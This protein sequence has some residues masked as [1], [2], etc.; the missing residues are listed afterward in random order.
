M[1]KQQGSL[2]I[3]SGPSGVGKTTLVTHFLQQY[4]HLYNIDRVV[5]YTTKQPRSTEVCGVDYHFITQSEFQDKIKSGFFLEWSGEYGAFY[6][7]PLHIIDALACGASK[8]LVIDRVGA[9]QI[10]KR[11]PETILCW[12]Q[13]SS[14]LELMNRLANRK[15]ESSEQVQVRLLLAKKEIEQEKYQPMYHHYIENNELKS[16]VQKLF[17]V[18]ASECQFIQKEVDRF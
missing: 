13:V 9:A 8:I 10:I 6:G 12:V 2:F 14:E 3:V 18:V 15:T 1:I 11:H 7:T 5:T 4:R 16:A 17:D